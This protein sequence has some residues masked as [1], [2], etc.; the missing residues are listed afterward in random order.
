[1]QG[2]GRRVRGLGLGGT[3][4]TPSPTGD[5]GE[6]VGGGSMFCYYE[7]CILKYSGETCDA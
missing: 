7:L 3:S 1:M 4:R 5:E 6:D 2:A